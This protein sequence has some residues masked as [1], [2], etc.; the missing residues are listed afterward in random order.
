[1]TDGKLT[2]LNKQHLSAVIDSP[3]NAADVL[4][5]TIDLLRSKYPHSTLLDDEA[6]M[7]RFLDV[8]KVISSFS[9]SD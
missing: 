6:A 1:M 7:S 8:M 2:F 3:E 9:F 5:R 4:Q